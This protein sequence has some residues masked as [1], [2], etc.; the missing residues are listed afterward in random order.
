MIDKKNGLVTITL[1]SGAVNVYN[2]KTGRYMKVIYN[3]TLLPTWSENHRGMLGLNHDGAET[4]LRY[5]DESD[6][7]TLID[8]V[9]V[10]SQEH[11]G[12]ENP[13]DFIWKNY[14]GKTLS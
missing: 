4:D 3:N 2:R 5:R 6:G 12:P 1:P 10:E 9:D 7:I 8:I 14:P 13:N 11:V